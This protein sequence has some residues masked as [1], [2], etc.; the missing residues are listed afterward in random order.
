M[1]SI[2]DQIDYIEWDVM[3]VGMYRIRRDTKENENENFSC[4]EN[5]ELLYNEAIFC[6]VAILLML[7]VPVIA[8][9]VVYRRIKWIKISFLKS[10]SCFSSLCHFDT[11]QQHRIFWRHKSW[12]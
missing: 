4:C 9:D 3:C 7:N 2:W 10:I 1:D 11:V 12:M 5:C 8:D 6:I